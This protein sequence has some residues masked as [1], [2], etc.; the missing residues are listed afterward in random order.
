MEKKIIKLRIIGLGARGI[1]LLKLAIFRMKDVEVVA[2]CDVYAD[3]VDSVKKLAKKFRRA[4]PKGYTDYKELLADDEIQTVI[5]SC[6]WKMHTEIVVAA[7]RAGKTVASEVGGAYDVDECWRLVNAYEETKTPFMVLENCC[8]G[9]YELA[10]LNMVRKGLFGTVV[11]CE[12]GYRHDL[13]DEI[14]YGNKNRHY[15][16]NEY[17]NRNCENYPTHEI[18]PISKLLDINY[19]N[20]FVWLMSVSSKACGLSEYVKDNEEKHSEL[21]ELDG[22]EFKQGDIVHTTIKCAGGELI[23]ITLDTT[24]PRAYSRQFTVHGTK[25]SYQEDGNVFFIDDVKYHH[26][27][28]FKQSMLYN[29]GRYYARKYRHPIWKWFRSRGVKGGHGGMDWLV[30]RA[31][32][33]AVKKGDGKMPLDVYD[34]ASWMVI[35]AL[36][37]ISIK[38]D[39]QPVEFPDFTRGAW[40]SRKQSG[41]GMFFLDRL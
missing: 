3:R 23:H 4:E 28:H 17:I 34:A 18:G 40:Q 12:G 1:G 11:G 37:D 9:E 31:F 39:S 35:T 6:S 26:A 38:N 22:V 32:F 2:V 19:G 20:R 25:A 7:M 10:V 13:R 29:N 27:V 16:L 36:S 15:R 14:C 24:L 8:Y 30:L 5:V 33:D 21:R 41:E